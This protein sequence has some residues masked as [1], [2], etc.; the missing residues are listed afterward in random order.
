[1]INNGYY[2]NT[3]RHEKSRQDSLRRDDV[4]LCKYANKQNSVTVT[5]YELYTDPIQRHVVVP[6]PKSGTSSPS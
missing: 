2:Y 3:K 5:N 1:M 4:R 6:K